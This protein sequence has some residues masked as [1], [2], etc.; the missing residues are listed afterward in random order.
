MTV[1]KKLIVLKLLQGTDMNYL[2]VFIFN[3][4]MLIAIFLEIFLVR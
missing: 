3:I 1:N 2:N 4:Q